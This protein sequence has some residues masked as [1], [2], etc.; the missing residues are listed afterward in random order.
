MVDH[1]GGLEFQRGEAG[2]GE[3]PFGTGA[4]GGTVG[5]GD[6]AGVA[7]GRCCD[8]EAEGGGGG[9]PD[10]WSCEKGRGHPGCEWRVARAEETE[11]EM[12]F[13]LRR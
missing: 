13:G 10:G 11:L 7:V 1:L 3:D 4:A 8:A 9:G 5:V 6:S 12:V 2:A